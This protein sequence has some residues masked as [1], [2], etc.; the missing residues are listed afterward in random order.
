[1]HVAQNFDV[2]AWGETKLKEKGECEFGC[3]SGRIS[4]VSKM[5]SGLS[6][7]FGNETVCSE[8]EGIVI[9]A[10]LCKNKAWVKVVDA[11]ICI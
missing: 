9:K 3:V 4:G 10:D 1:M 2:L 11:C 7:E 8:V 5:E 6:S